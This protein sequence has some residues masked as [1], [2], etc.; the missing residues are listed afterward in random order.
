ME[1]DSRDSI[2]AFLAEA[3][4]E[5]EPRKELLSRGKK[6]RPD[7]TVIGVGNTSSLRLTKLQAC[8]H[9]KVDVESSRTVKK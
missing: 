3:L 9:I 5:R 2:E 6:K 1:E 4:V 8:V 7:L